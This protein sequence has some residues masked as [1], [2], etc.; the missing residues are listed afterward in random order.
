MTFK[1]VNIESFHFTAVDSLRDIPI[2]RSCLTSMGIP[3]IN[4]WKSQNCLI[5]KMR[6][7][8]HGKTDFILKKSSCAKWNQYGL[9]MK[10]L[11][12]QY[13]NSYHK[14]LIFIMGIPIPGKMVLWLRW[15][16]HHNWKRP[17]I[18]RI[19]KVLDRTQ[20]VLLVYRPDSMY[21]RRH[22][23]ELAQKWDATPAC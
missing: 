11:C 15:G 22:F 5:F 2:G 12:S 20:W 17:P 10:M 1:K 14:Y 7:P 13:R 4:I 23:N 19:T 18:P 8:I 3:I 6:I 9:N 16:Q 21:R